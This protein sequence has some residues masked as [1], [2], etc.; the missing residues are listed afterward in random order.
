MREALVHVGAVCK[1]K[2]RPVSYRLECR[3]E[4]FV[5]ISGGSLAS[6]GR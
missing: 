4:G 1:A 5:R 3:H 6:R 2:S